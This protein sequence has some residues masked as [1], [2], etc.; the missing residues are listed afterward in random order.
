MPIY[1]YQ[2]EKCAHVTEV[3]VSMDARDAGVTCE[4][5]GSEKTEKLL[6]SFAAAVK[7]GVVP[8]LPPCASGG[9]CSGGACPHAGH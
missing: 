6:S 5:C 4:K 8:S 1:E 2:C 9:A 3:R 7:G